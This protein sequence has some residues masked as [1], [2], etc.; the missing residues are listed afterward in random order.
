M[1]S[2]QK[3][4]HNVN[5]GVQGIKTKPVVKKPDVEKKP[6]VKNVKKKPDVKKPDINKTIKKPVVRSTPGPKQSKR[7]SFHSGHHKGSRLKSHSGSK[8]KSERK[9]RSLQQSLMRP[10]SHSGNTRKTKRPASHSGKRNPANQLLKQA[11]LEA[12]SQRIIADL[13]KQVLRNAATDVQ[14]N[15]GPLIE[16][17]K[18]RIAELADLHDWKRSAQSSHV[19]LN[20]SCVRRFNKFLGDG[21]QPDVGKR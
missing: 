17:Y 20:A 7:P 14:C 5:K 19:A 2:R 1:A 18:K 13:R 9:P 12:N 6:D 21:L 8:R 16:Y 4:S 10:K 3:G 11:L 15:H